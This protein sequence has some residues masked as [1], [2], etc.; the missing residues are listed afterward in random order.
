MATKKQQQK[1]DRIL[2]RVLR[3]LEIDGQ[4][5]KPDAVIE[6]FSDHVEIY[7][8]SVDPHPDAVAHA[9]SLQE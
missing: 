9:K 1:P 4:I 2:V 7:A 3:E 5:F 6:M 8:G